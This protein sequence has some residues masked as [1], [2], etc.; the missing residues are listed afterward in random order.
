MSRGRTLKV[1]VIG[2]GWGRLHILGYQ[3]NENAEVVAFCQ[4]TKDKAET[5]AEEFNIPHI[6]TNYRDLLSLKELDAVSITAPPYLHHRM[7]TDAIASGIH[8]LCEK[9][10]AKNVSEAE[11]MY[12]RAERAGVVHMTAFPRRFFPA[13]TYAKELLDQGYVG[14]V[15]HIN[16]RMFSVYR[17][18]PTKVTRWRHRIEMSGAGVMGDMGVHQIDVL[19]WIVGDF[20]KVCGHCKIFIKERP[21]PDGSGKEE[22]TTEDSAAFLAELEGGVKAVTHISGV[23]FKRLYQIEIYGNKGMLYCSFDENPPYVLGN[24]LGTQKLDET[25]QP[26]PLP[27]RLTEKLRQLPGVAA[28]RSIAVGRFI[29]G[30]HVIQRFVQGILES[31]QPEP[32]FREGLEAQK[33]LEAILKSSKEGRWIALKK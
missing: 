11:D 27:T 33:V 26:I 29:Y 12:K 2:G 21:L 18:T 5:I 6:F 30:S 14:K 23:S 16:T 24:L 8:V 7:A 4:R 10:L 15:L 28:E 3:V 32:S 19:R 22:I 1:G 25:P 13:L 9:P 20:R 31:K 17:L